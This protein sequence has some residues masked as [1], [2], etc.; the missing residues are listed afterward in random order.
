MNSATA[1]LGRNLTLDNLINLIRH[2]HVL[3]NRC[4]MCCAD[5][6][7]VDHLF[8]HCPVASRLWGF[9]F[10]TLWGC[11]DSTKRGVRYALGLAGC[12]DWTSTAAGVAVG[13]VLLDVACLV[14]AKSMNFSRGLSRYCVVRELA[15]CSFI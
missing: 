2:G 11:L 8:M 10:F 15:Y 1:A 7:S 12:S 13:A 5:V 14:G 3:V 6:E 4:C 9:I